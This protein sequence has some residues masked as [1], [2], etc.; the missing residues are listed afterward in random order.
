MAI[1]RYFK[2]VIRLSSFFSLY[3]IVI[4][5]LLFMQCLSDGVSI[6]GKGE[7]ESD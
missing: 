3:A 4:V 7:W 2:R 5:N 6:L 1:Q